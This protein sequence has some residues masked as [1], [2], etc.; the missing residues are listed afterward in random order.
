MNSTTLNKG[1]GRKLPIPNNIFCVNAPLG[2]EFFRQWC[3]FIRPFVN[4]TK[5]ET[6]VV[7]SL[8]KQ[9]WELSKE[10]SNP[11]LIDE[12]LLGDKVK[13]KVLEECNLTLQHFYV[14]MGTLRKHKVIVNNA[15]EPRL[16]PNIR[17]ND[18]GTFQ[19]LILI[20]NG[21]KAS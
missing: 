3:V 10:V 9:R 14:I 17:Q 15:L 1:A 20:K 19:L 8:L 18:D 21:V 7:A 5:R 6:D 12:M 11:A 4:L 16:I 13:N 2:L